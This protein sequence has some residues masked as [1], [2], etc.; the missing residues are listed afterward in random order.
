MDKYTQECVTLGDDNTANNL[1]TTR[2]GYSPKPFD[3]ILFGKA[4][5]WIFLMIGFNRTLHLYHHRFMTY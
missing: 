5:I 3:T 1:A 2:I 4:N